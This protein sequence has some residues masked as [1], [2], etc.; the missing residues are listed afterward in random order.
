MRDITPG[1]IIRF[2][3][4]KLALTQEEFGSW[5][6]HDLGRDRPYSQPQVAAWEN[7]SRSPRLKVRIACR[8]L[9]ADLALE[10]I[11]ETEDVEEAI[12]LIVESQS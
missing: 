10:I 6:A 1:G 8:E 5:L 2:C 9:A 11:D 4:K 12:R 7:G 3:R